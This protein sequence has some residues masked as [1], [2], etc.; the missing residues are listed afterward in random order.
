VKK[1]KIDLGRRSYSI[2]IGHKVIAGM[3][4]Q[5]K[6]LRLGTRAIVVTNPAVR[7]RGYLK[8]LTKA[9]RSSGCDV[10]V[11]EIPG[12]ETSK[13]FKW[14]IALTERIVKL[15][16]GRGVFIVVL[17][18]GTTGD[19]GGYVASAY[20]RGVPYIQIPTTLLAQVDS[21]IGGKTAI[22]LA[23]GKNLI[24]A[25]YQ[26]RLVVSD[27]SYL[28]GLPSRVFKSA[29]GEIIKYGV[30]ADASLFTFLEK[31]IAK[32]LRRDKRC[33]EHIIY[34]SSK[35]KAGIVEKDEY[36]RKGVRAILNFGHTIGHAI[37][38]ASGYSD[39][40]FYYHG[41]AIALGM[42]AASRVAVDLGVFNG[43][44]AKRVEGL[45]KAA[46]LPTRLSSKLSVGKIM[47]AQIHDKKVVRGVNR[48]IL[49]TRIG[50]VKVCKAVP[51]APILNAVK[52]L[53]KGDHAL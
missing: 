51:R 23:S 8:P 50:K 24:G 27:T 7:R 30:I 49:P 19:L 16:S 42:I 13:S 45:I 2:V 18:G 43:R 17:G 10:H 4:A 9:L 12:G 6:A 25:F 11:A 26:P 52:S 21:A 53:M 47:K 35:I 48:F 28:D 34:R 22:D 41:E 29:L 40:D 46:G 5:I 39:R 33:L 44:S 3:A 37:E 31:N 1:I 32:V 36:D 14:V 38:T 15:D 20:K